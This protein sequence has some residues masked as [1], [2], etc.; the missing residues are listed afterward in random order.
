MAKSMEL[1][2]EILGYVTNS[3]FHSPATFKASPHLEWLNSVFMEN[4]GL[5]V[6]M[7]AESSDSG[8]FAGNGHRRE[9][10]ERGEFEPRSAMVIWPRRE[11]L[12]W[13]ARH[14]ELEEESLRQSVTN[15][16]EK[17][18]A[19]KNFRSAEAQAM[20]SFLTTR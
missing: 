6:D 1:Q 10:W 9:L 12:N 8:V 14:P 20:M 5:V 2:P 15:G 4:G 3:W 17:Q 7:G 11:M 16:A 18:T 13:A 19:G